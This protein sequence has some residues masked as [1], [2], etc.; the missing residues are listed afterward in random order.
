[1]SRSVRANVATA[2]TVATG[3]DPSFVGES[4]QLQGKADFVGIKAY[5]CNKRGEIYGRFG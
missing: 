2:G 4:V 3:A 5:P 1:M